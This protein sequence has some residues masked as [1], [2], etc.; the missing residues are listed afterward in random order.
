MNI[1]SIDPGLSA[2]TNT[3]PHGTGVAVFEHGVIKATFFIRGIDAPLKK[4]MEEVIETINS[5]IPDW[6]RYKVVIEQ[7][8]YQNRNVARTCYMFLGSLEYIFGP[9][10]YIAPTSVKKLVC[11][12]GKAEK[13]DIYQTLQ[14][15]YSH[16]E[17]FKRI[18]WQYD[19]VVDAVA[20]G[21]AWIKQHTEGG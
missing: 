16:H 19:D 10:E 17:L 6:P 7:S 18:H 4:R 5:S 20:V 1:I 2:G 15:V 3:K 21:Y 9:C 14:Q 12:S 8:H 11:G 13:K